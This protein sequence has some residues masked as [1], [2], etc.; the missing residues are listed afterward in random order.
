MP[1]DAPKKP[2]DPSANTA[3]NTLM[4]TAAAAYALT[5]KRA[6]SDTLQSAGKRIAT[7]YDDNESK[8]TAKPADQP[9]TPITDLVIQTMDAHDALYNTVKQ[10]KKGIKPWDSSRTDY[11]LCV[12][13]PR[14]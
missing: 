5:T 7:Y 6:A 4:T 3:K 2:T 9:N 1:T 8:P 10:L 12:T 14:R 11:E 13:Y